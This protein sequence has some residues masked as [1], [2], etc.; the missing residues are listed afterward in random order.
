MPTERGGPHWTTLRS[1]SM[2]GS[3]DEF[4]ISPDFFYHG[5][6]LVH[7]LQRCHLVYPPP[8]HPSQGDPTDEWCELLVISSKLD[9]EDVRARAIEEL[10]ANASKVSPVDRIKLGTK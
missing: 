10:T 2:N 8:T 3:L 1:Q 9:R 4:V 5:F 6:V 7:H